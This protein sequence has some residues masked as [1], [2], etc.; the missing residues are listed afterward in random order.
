MVASKEVAVS[1]WDEWGFRRPRS[2]LAKF[3]GIQYDFDAD[4]DSEGYYAIAL[5]EANKATKRGNAYV[6]MTKDHRFDLA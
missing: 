4:D 5:S 1:A 3:G 6:N 2:W